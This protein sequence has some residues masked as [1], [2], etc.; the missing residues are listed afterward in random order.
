ME[1]SLIIPT[2]Q[3][4]STMSTQQIPNAFSNDILKRIQ[5]S[6][7]LRII[8][9]DKCCPPCQPITLHVYTL[10]AIDDDFKSNENELYL[11]K[12]VLTPIFCGNLLC[13]RNDI[14]VKCYAGQN[15]SLAT[16]YFCSYRI[17][18][19]KCCPPD[20]SECFKCK[21]FCFRCSCENEILLPMTFDIAPSKLEIN[22]DNNELPFGRIE[23]LITC[24]TKLGIRRFYDYGQTDNFKY[25]IGNEN[26]SCGVD[27]CCSCCKNIGCCECCKL[28]RYKFK[29]IMN[30][31]GV[32]CGEFDMVDEPFL[33]GCCHK[34][35]YEIKF[36]NDATV[37]LKLLLLGGLF[38]AVLI[39][40]LSNP[41]PV[42][43]KNY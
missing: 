27:C 9:D 21:C 38:D 10:S 17:R 22:Q 12:A 32:E 16:D 5:A 28:K 14:E 33:M 25:Q 40:Y 11:F 23:R 29:T 42:R 35:S 13:C 19:P 4:S 15:S 36:P 2:N 37:P 43:I 31:E 8:P 3:T 39:P 34:I 1:S 7:Y 41:L 30:Q 24:C 18:V 26:C 6:P 20:F